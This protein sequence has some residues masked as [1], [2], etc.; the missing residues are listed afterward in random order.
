MSELGE[1]RKADEIGRRGGRNGSWKFIWHACIECGRERWVHLLLRGPESLRCSKHNGRHQGFAENNTNWCTDTTKQ[2]TGRM[3][4]IRWYS[5]QP[6]E[7]CGEKAERHHKDGNAL[8]NEPSNIAFRCRKHHMEIDGRLAK[9]IES[10]KEYN[11]RN[12]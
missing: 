11:R 2:Q 12:V 6:C 8:N 4:A 3:R 9:V 1:I 10:A 5:L 7:V